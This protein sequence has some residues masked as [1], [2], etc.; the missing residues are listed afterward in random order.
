M[1][2]DT[3]GLLCLHNRAEPFHAHARTLYRAA[4]IRLTHSDV[5]QSVSRWPMHGVYPVGQRLIDRRMLDVVLLLML[6]TARLGQVLTQQFA[7]RML[8]DPAA[9]IEALNSRV[10]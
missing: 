2:L 8:E 9:I 7:P 3:S 10:P 6:S 1:L 4:R 5:L